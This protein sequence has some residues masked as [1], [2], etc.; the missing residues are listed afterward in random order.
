MELLKNKILEEGRVLG[1]DVLKVDSFLNHQI[2][3]ELFN[4][5]GKEF[6][7]RFQNK[8]VTKILTIEAS[9]IGIACIT[10]QY[11]NVP[12]VFAKKHEATNMDKDNYEAEI[13]S[14]TKN[15]SYTIKVSK[16]YIL[17]EDKVLIIDDFLANANAA[18]A[19][20]SVVE[21]A[22][23]EVVGVGIVIEKG[24]QNGRKV[25]EDKNIKL[26]SLAILESMEDGKVIF[27]KL[28]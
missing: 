14:F 22:K 17:P 11:F 26:E 15:K 12:V 8:E 2:D 9:G 16:K 25:I 21:Q 20:I 6:K 3:V 5:I 13:F 19:L 18:S 27:K 10:A 28:T 4:E 1:K 24:F 23:A 7:K